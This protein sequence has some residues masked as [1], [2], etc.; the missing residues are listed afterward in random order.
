MNAD[1]LKSLGYLKKSFGMSKKAINNASYKDPQIKVEL[2]SIFTGIE[3][4]INAID[5]KEMEQL[6]VTGTVPV[7]TLPIPTPAPVAPHVSTNG[8]DFLDPNP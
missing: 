6:A 1:V 3:D 4:L 7:T 8:L 5:A 2:N